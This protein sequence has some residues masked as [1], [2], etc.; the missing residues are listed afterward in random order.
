MA[1]EAASSSGSPGEV[2]RTHVVAV[3]EPPSVPVLSAMI[4]EWQIA[5]T[6]KESQFFSTEVSARGKTR[7]WLLLIWKGRG[8]T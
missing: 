4:D 1:L 5:G 8:R 2:V 7:G 3:S 6:P